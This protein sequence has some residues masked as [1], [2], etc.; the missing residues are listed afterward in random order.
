MTEPFKIADRAYDSRLI[1]GTG[2]APSLEILRE[3]LIASGTRLTTVAMRRV[4][5]GTRGS[6]LDLLAELNAAGTTIVAVT[7]DQ[8]VADRMRRQVRMLDGRIVCDTAAGPAPPL[9]G[10]RRPDE[11]GERLP[12]RPHPGEGKA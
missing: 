9:A 10:R 4:A 7:H 3:A 2:G 11:P 1:M 5:A 12:G 6:I 8:L